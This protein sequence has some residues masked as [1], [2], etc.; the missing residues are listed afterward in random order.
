MNIFSRMAALSAARTPFVWATVTDTGGSTPQL[1]GASMAV[2]ADDQT[3]T[4]GGGAFELRVVETCRTMLVLG[5]ERTS[6]VEVHLVRD[7]AMCCGGR[8]TAFLQKV[9]P[10]PRLFI[11]GAGHVGAAL[12]RVALET[13]LEVHVIDARTDW[14]NRERFPEGVTLH[15]AESEDF[16][17]QRPPNAADYAVITTHSHP[18]DQA[19]TQA[20]APLSLAF[21]GLIGSRA[22]WARFR[23]RLVERGLTAE[24]LDSVQCPVGLELGATTPAEIAVSIVAALVQRRRRGR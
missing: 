6:T 2:T 10:A 11:F 18:L 16:I 1:A 22:K 8:M 19:L 4:V 15:D 12:A 5:G 20:L 9:E 3:G 17:A 14:L 13:E 21:L 7:L 23:A 24:Q